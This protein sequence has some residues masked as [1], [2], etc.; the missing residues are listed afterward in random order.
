[1]AFA[2]V[3]MVDHKRFFGNKLMD[4]AYVVVSKKGYFVMYKSIY[5]TTGYAFDLT[6]AK[7]I[8][9]TEKINAYGKVVSVKQLLM[10]PCLL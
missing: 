3:L 5:D 6:S 7:K 8:S 1:M 4:S 9:V 2:E 10:I